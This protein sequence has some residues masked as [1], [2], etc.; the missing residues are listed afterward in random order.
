MDLQLLCQLVLLLSTAVNTRAV[1]GLQDPAPAIHAFLLTV[2]K[3]QCLFLSSDYPLLG[4]NYSSYL[5]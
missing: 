2:G 1:K 4:G 3:G 5:L